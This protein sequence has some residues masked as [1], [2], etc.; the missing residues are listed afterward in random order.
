VRRTLAA[1]VAVFAA[2][3][4]SVW[5]TEGGPGGAGVAAPTATEVVASAVP[6]A[7]GVQR[8]EVTMGDDLRFTPTVVRAR[9]GIIELTF[10]N[11]G[12]TP[13]DPQVESV[14]AGNIN[15]GQARPVRVSIDRPGTYPF[16]CG[17]HVSSGMQGRIEVS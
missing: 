13:H 4:C 15:G 7:D 1:L 9:P 2:T 16:P 8:V 14:T 3:G 11:L 6:G 5:G 10:R 12:S 17:Y